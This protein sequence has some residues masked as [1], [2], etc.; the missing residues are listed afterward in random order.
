MVSDTRIYSSPHYH[1]AFQYDGFRT[2]NTTLSFTIP[3]K[4][5]Y[6]GCDVEW[7]GC[8][9]EVW[10]PN[11]N[12]IPVYPGTPPS[13]FSMVPPLSHPRTDGSG[14]R[15]DWTLVPQHLD[16]K[17]WHHPFI[18]SPKYGGGLVEFEYL[19]SVWQLSPG[20][21]SEEFVIRLRD[22]AKELEERRVSSLRLIPDS[23]RHLTYL[24]DFHPSDEEII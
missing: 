10:S 12:H 23:F 24:I 7:E 16:T 20:R 14:G 3:G 8:R 2:F 19:T 15:F 9:F 22:R 21:L 17:K 11:A 6:V 5:E 13:S 1:S 18:I 4:F